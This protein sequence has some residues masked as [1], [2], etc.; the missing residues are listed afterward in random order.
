MFG[1]RGPGWRRQNWLGD[2]APKDKARQ[3][4]T[5]MA[6]A[7]FL[8]RDLQVP[9]GNETEDH[10]PVPGNLDKFLGSHN[11]HIEDMNG[12]LVNSED[13]DLLYD[14][15]SD[16][17]ILLSNENG[18]PETVTVTTHVETPTTDFNLASTALVS[19][20]TSKY[21][22]SS[23]PRE[24]GTSSVSIKLA[25]AVASPTGRKT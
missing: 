8:K 6:S 10:D 21:L 25:H 1:G 14:D 23:F 18:F 15:Y 5:S 7:A 11:L 19:S 3:R 9:L 20:R 4:P 16:A 17:T 24:T 22:G 12:N 13:C 2:P